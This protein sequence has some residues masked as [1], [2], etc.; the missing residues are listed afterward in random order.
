M[1]T[2]AAPERVTATEYDP[3]AILGPFPNARVRATPVPVAEGRALHRVWV[4]RRRQ[5][6]RLP[7]GAAPKPPT[8][9]GTLC[10]RL[11]LGIS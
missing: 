9:P 5:E 3:P 4:Y 6:L 10:S 11:Q 8:G 2:G 7:L 1:E